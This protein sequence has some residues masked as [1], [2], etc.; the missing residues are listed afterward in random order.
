LPL[1]HK[2]AKVHKEL[3]INELSLAQLS[4]FVPLWQK[5]YISELTQLFNINIFI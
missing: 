2:D 4:A 5:K 1:R 3:I